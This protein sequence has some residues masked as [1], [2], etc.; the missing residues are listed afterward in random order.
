MKFLVLGCNGMAGHML[1][2]YLKEGG[3][4]VDGFARKESPF[5]HT[6]LGDAR[7]TGLLRNIIEKG[8]YRAVIN[9]IGVLNKFAELNHE[10]A[11]FLNSYIPQFLAK[12]TEKSA[13]QIIHIST[14]CV[15]SGSRGCYTESDFPDGKLFYDRSKALGELDNEKDITFRMSIVGPDANEKG[16][17]L[18]NWFMQQQGK[19]KGYKNAMWTGQTTLQLAKTIEH[20][21]RQRVHGLYNM[22]P[23]DKISK[24]DMLVLFNQYLRSKPIEIEPEENFRTDKSLKRTNYGLFSYRIP[25]Y[26]QQIRELGTWMRAHKELYPHYGL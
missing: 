20:A 17:G 19:V 22:V 1:S 6:V 13:T 8:N 24:Y 11:V 4:E 10:A 7:D 23:E 14:D 21:A 16:I 9:C 2:L 15:F 26:E 12:I 3:Y 25:E 18:I 5:I